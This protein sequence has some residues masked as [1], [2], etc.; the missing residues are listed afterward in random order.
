[1]SSFFGQNDNTQSQQSPQFSG[2]STVEQNAKQTGGSTQPASTGASAAATPASSTAPAAAPGSAAPAAS[3]SGQAP[4]APAWTNLST[5]LGA[6]E[7]GAQQMAGQVTGSLNSAASVATGAAQ[8]AAQNIWSS[9]SGG[10]N[11]GSFSAVAP[12]ATAAGT[13]AGNL[14]ANTSGTGTGSSGTVTTSTPSYDLSKVNLTQY[15]GPSVQQAQQQ[16]ADA[17]AKAAT[18][19]QDASAAQ[20]GQLEHNAW[21]NALLTQTPQWSQI[22]Q[23]IGGANQAAAT[24]NALANSAQEAAAQGQNQS[25]ANIA[26]QR[27]QLGVAQGTLSSAA[28]QAA[29]SASQAQSS[30][31]TDLS[32]GRGTGQLQTDLATY[33]GA[34]EAAGMPADKLQQ[35]ETSLSNGSMTRADIASALQPFLSA[36]NGSD[37]QTQLGAAQT[38]SINSLLGNDAPTV[39]AASTGSLGSLQTTASDASNYLRNLGSYNG[40]DTATHQEINSAIATMLKQGMTPDQIM[41]AAGING[42]FA[43]GELQQMQ[44]AIGRGFSPQAAYDMATESVLQDA[45]QVGHDAYSDARGFQDYVNQTGF[46]TA[47]GHSVAPPTTSSKSS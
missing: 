37:G 27:Q 4:Q 14:T 32:S 44:Q 46:D 31:S 17:Q 24:G 11:T 3:S 20:S 6:N 28:A 25:A 2:T 43:A 47:N 22:Q 18:A 39:S 9:A 41:Q 19:S 21:D 10:T 30:L 36:M 16:T 23:A 33:A 26:A 29:S 40:N 34:L 1:M 8:G 38:N 42:G 5:F 13:T 12:A 35:M 15:Q 7:A 45:G